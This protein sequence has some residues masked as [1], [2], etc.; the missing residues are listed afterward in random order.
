MR[1]VKFLKIVSNFLITVHKSL[2]ENKL[3]QSFRLKLKLIN[4]CT[5]TK[6]FWALILLE[7]ER[8]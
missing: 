5:S 3:L 2:F 1:Q 7:K 4:K 8:T 6:R